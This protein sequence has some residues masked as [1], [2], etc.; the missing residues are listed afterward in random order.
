MSRRAQFLEVLGIPTEWVPRTPVAAPAEARS[1][2]AAQPAAI[3]VAE[4]P[5]AVTAAPVA[6]AV[7]HPEAPPAVPAA[8]PAPEHAAQA[9]RE[10]AI[11]A[12]DWPALEAAVAGCTACGLCQTRTNTVF[13][14]GAR[15]AEWMLV[16]EA[17][18]ENED[19]Q[20][21][22]FVGQAGKLLDNML[23]ALGLARGRNVFIA[24]VLKCR[25]PGNRNPEAEE[26]A[27]CEPFLRR[28]IA[29][30][31]PRVIVVLGRFAAQ[32]LLRTTTPIGKL[33]GTV[34]AYEGIPVVVTYHPA[35]LLRTL[36][37][38]ARAWEDLCLAREVHDRAGA[39][40]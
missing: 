27:Q 14:V 22:P 19:L 6:A 40:A 8:A 35:Y 15:Q 37:D 12:M 16:G 39:G 1:D 25:P 28:Q 32:S 33:R 38:K 24:N 7:A 5:A 34:H 11:A 13:G 36:T 10:A 4:P 17:P 31:R 26:V 3:P 9:E 23:G 30:V 29:L 2:V 18:G 20:G 21:E